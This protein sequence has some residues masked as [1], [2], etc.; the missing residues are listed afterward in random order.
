MDTVNAIS[1]ALG[2]MQAARLRMDMAAAVLAKVTLVAPPDP[3]SGAAGAGSAGT[4]IAAAL[5]EQMLSVT[6]FGLN[7]NVARTADEMLAE[8]LRLAGGVGGE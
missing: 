6:T 4:D 5:V 1:S 2:G 3:W 7:V 8:T